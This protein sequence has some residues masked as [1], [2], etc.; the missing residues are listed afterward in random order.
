MGRRAIPRRVLWRAALK[1]ERE[2]LGRA[3][4]HVS[5]AIRQKGRPF[6]AS[7]GNKR[8]TSTPGARHVQARIFERESRS[9]APE[10]SSRPRGP[11][12]RGTII[13]LIIS[14]LVHGALV[15]GFF[16]TVP[17]DTGSRA[18][19]SEKTFTIRWSRP[20]T[21]RPAPQTVPQKK[22]PPP[23]PI[24]S[25]ERGAPTAE[26]AKST[27]PPPEDPAVR[28][29]PRPTFLTAPPLGVGASPAGRGASGRGLRGRL[30]RKGR[31]LI[32]YGGDGTDEAVSLGLLWLSKH[33]SQNG[34]WSASDFR[35][36]C[37]RHVPCSSRGLNEFDVG[38][39]ALATLA[40]LGAGH[41]PPVVD[42]DSTAGPFRNTV[43]RALEF[44]GQQQEP[45]GAI[46][47]IGDHYNYNH[48]LA[49]LAL[50]EAGALTG[51]ERYIRQGERALTF[52]TRTQQHRGGWD[53]GADK[54]NRNDLSVTGWQI[55][56]LTVAAS[57]GIEVPKRTRERATRFASQALTVDG[58]GVY[59][60]RGTERDRR[61][62]NMAAVGLLTNLLT[63][64]ERR[65]PRLRRATQR[66]LGAVPNWEQTSR[67]ETTFQS[68]YY[69][70]TGTLALFHLGGKDWEA[71]NFFLKRTLL[72][73][74]RTRS[75]ARGSW[76]PEDNW[77]GQSGG[78]VYATAI[79]VLTLETY[80]R[81]EP[82]H[83]TGSL[84]SRQP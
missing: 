15:W 78:R 20:Q 38:V 30:A 36:H 58:Q 68:Y 39:S 22:P 47:A 73:L 77:I 82:L 35:R 7:E 53:Y 21:P 84:G 10:L 61:G 76:P 43:G 80:Y 24:P 42:D 62:V 33:Q 13:P 69:W 79:A 71:W 67:W 12:R 74:Q 4:R 28:T 66:L 50:L 65:T 44:L 52:T 1:R 54:T 18:P 17:R 37:G 23:Q 40:F 48:A 83:A 25:P 41:L 2:Q 27:E 64:S 3:L 70:Y 46:G 72:P 81:Y 5:R 29:T 31:A 63:S 34:G 60:D 11:L 57:T 16:L 9:G 32:A 8:R 6:R 55:M 51:V 45:G 75:H 49:T 56:A 19:S 26:I 14:A 59:A